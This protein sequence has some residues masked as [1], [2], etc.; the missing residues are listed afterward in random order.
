MNVA[1]TGAAQ[2]IGRAIALRLASEGANIT[3]SDLNLD[4]AEKVAEEVM[5]L[6]R[7]ALAVRSDVTVASDCDNLVS[8]SA[9]HFGRLDMLV[10]N[11]GFIQV[12]PFLDITP[13]DLDRLLSVNVKGVYFSVQAGARQM[14]RQTP[15]GPGRPKGKIV[16]MSSIAAR[17]GAGPMAPFTAPYRASKAA[18]VSITQSAAYSFAPDIT[19][20]AICPGLVETDMW[21]TMDKQMAALKKQPEGELWKQRVSAV[22][23]GRGQTPED[24]AGLASYLA[25]TDA[26]Y[27]TGQ[28]I[29]IEGGL[30][31]S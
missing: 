16:T 7:S 2:G 27:M 18:V 4:G 1:I 22:P 17:Y 5:A 24:V 26:D 31:M 23:M 29:N 28:S 15:L 8:I 10:C 9:E 25:S 20:N 19:V 6:G 14:L 3:I 11:A 12:K 30:T 21:K 13:D